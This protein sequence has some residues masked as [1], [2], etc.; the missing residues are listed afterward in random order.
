M[1]PVRYRIATVLLLL[2]ALLGAGHLAAPTTATALPLTATPRVLMLGD[3]LTWQACTGPW[4]QF[5][6]DA[7]DW[8]EQRDGGCYGYAGATTADMQYMVQGGRF[9]SPDPGQPHPYLP[10]RGMA[11]PYSLWE[12]IDRADVLVVGLGTN[13]AGR[14]STCTSGQTPWPV[15]HSRP[16]ADGGDWVPCAPTD[17]Q[18][19]ATIDFFMWLAQGKPVFWYDVAVTNPADPAYP[20]ADEVNAEIWDA[21]RRHLNFRPIPWEHAAAAHPEY[22]REDGV[23]LTDTGRAARHR[24]LYD[25]IRGSG[26]R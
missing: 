18:I 14:R 20:Y 10:G 4:Q 13:D 3:S 25:V 24:L 11:N 2:V 1:T 19:R 6:T 5:G 22:L 21:A 26:I 9:Y 7:P 17:G 16:L 15:Q 12:A 8:L 23:H